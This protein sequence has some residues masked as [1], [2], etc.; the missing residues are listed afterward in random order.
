M[1][2][3]L[4]TLSEKNFRHQ[5]W[6]NSVLDL[7]G[8]G[9]TD[10]KLNESQLTILRENNDRTLTHL[11]TLNLSEW[12]QGNVN[13]RKVVRTF[14]KKLDYNEIICDDNGRRHCD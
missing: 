13:F 12:K 8:N 7:N 1:K 14:S 6:R 9:S 2:N 11:E 5:K 10:L 3:W 4:K